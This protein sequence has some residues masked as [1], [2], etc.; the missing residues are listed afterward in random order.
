MDFEKIESRLLISSIALLSTKGESRS[1]QAEAP[2]K[3]P[4]NAMDFDNPQRYF[5]KQSSGLNRHIQP[6]RQ[7][8]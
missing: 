2:S 7:N 3:N 4:R 6:R 5:R 1:R 8:D